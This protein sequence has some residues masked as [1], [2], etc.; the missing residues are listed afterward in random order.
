VVGA[1][2][3]YTGKREERDMHLQVNSANTR[4][5]VLH[6]LEFIQMPQHLNR[7]ELVA[8]FAEIFRVILPDTLNI[9]RREPPGS[10]L[11][12]IDI[13][14]L[15]ALCT[16]L[17]DRQIINRSSDHE[18][19][20]SISK[21]TREIELLDDPRGHLRASGPKL[22]AVNCKRCHI[23]GDSQLRLSDNHNF[24]VRSTRSAS[25]QRDFFPSILTCLSLSVTMT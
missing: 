14:A 17:S 2:V 8:T 23:V 7:I 19:M 4:N 1:S 20:S 22:Y 5:A 18:M 10:H 15:D 9:G 24:S 3:Q 11:D 21:V 6:S 25:S 16:R 12:E 13:D